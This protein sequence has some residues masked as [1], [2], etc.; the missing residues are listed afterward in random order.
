MMNSKLKAA[1]VVLA[2]LLMAAPVYAGSAVIGSVAGSLNATVGGQALLPNTVIFSGD[3]LQVKVGAAVIALETGRVR[4]QPQ[5]IAFQ[6]GSMR[7]CHFTTFA[8]GASPCSQ[9]SNRPPGFS[10][11]RDSASEAAGSCTEQRV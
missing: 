8:S 1:M 10:T 6:T 3:G 7:R 5:A 4:W 2:A 9:N 11:R